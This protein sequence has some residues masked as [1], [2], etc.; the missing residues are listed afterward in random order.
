[1]TA[2]EQYKASYRFHLERARKNRL[3]RP[4]SA[5]HW[6]LQSLRK[7]QVFHKKALLEA[8]YQRNVKEW[9]EEYS[10]YC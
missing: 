9:S 1:M 3:E 7:A 5:K 2:Y 6:A 8:R 10:E 4:I